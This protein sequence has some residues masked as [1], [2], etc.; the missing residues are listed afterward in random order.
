MYVYSKI[1]ASVKNYIIIKLNIYE[2]FITQCDKKIPKFL[3]S[4]FCRYS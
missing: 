1:A 2:I 4:S 3:F